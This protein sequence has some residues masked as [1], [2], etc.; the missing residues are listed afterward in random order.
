M[1]LCAVQPHMSDSI[2]ENVRGISRWIHRASD[3]GADVVVFPEMMLTGYDLHIVELFATSDW[4]A[5]VDEALNEL[6]SVVDVAG[7]S[8]LV[9]SPYRFGSGQLN[10]LLL[11]QPGK[12]IV[13]AGARSHLPVGDR[14]RLGFVEPR[15][16]SPVHVRGIALGS[17][18]CDEVHYLDYTQGK[19]LERSDI[20]LWNS[21]AMSHKNEKGDITRNHAEFAHG[22]ASFYG[23]PVIQSNYVSYASNASTKITVEKGRTLGG[24]V[25]CDASGQVLDQASWTEED[26]RSFEIS[27]VDGTVV[28]TPTA[29]EHLSEIPR[30]DVFHMSNLPDFDQLWDYNDPEKTEESVQETAARRTGFWRPRIPRSASHADRKNP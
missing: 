30:E 8:A 5:Q 9:G 29:G 3:S 20:I 15:D 4:H 14:N 2:D 10:A 24:S 13:L 11:L 12:E 1:K 6:G 28:V 21:V 27:R 16:R 25:A 23:V 18:F 22:I 19:G 17:V 26:M 7:I